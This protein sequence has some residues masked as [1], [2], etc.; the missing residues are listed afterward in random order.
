MGLIINECMGH[1]ITQ[2][3]ISHPITYERISVWM[4]GVKKCHLVTRENMHWMLDWLGTNSR[5]L[6][7][8][9][10]LPSLPAGKC[11][12]LASA[13]PMP[14]RV[15]FDP[16]AVALDNQ[17]ANS[18]TKHARQQVF[19][20]DMSAF[21]VAGEGM[22]ASQQMTFFEDFFETLKFW[23]TP[24]INWLD[25][26]V[27][28]EDIDGWTMVGWSG[29]YF[30]TNIFNMIYHWNN[31]ILK[32]CIEMLNYKALHIWKAKKGWLKGLCKK[33]IAILS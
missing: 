9:H 26:K 3:T 28:I 1:W 27:L 14:P 11:I 30:H 17:S 32:N 15:S 2:N 5:I 16:L 10:L 12:A 21:A 29:S 24:L 31:N 7:R 6:C 25:F 33:A 13:L 23:A 8:P 20:T 22:L 18:I 19:G 4:K